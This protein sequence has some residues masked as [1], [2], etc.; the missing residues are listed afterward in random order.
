MNNL[1]NTFATA[2]ASQTGIDQDSA[3][4]VVTWLINEGVLDAPVVAEEFNEQDPLGF[5][6]GTRD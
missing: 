1:Y 3:T 5:N 6:E 2:L 4:K